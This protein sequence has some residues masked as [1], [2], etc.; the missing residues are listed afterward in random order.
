[1]RSHVK[2]NTSNERASANGPLMR[3]GQDEHVGNQDADI[4]MIGPIDAS[5]E[6]GTVATT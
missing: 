1:M 2:A 6:Y 3:Y 4:S 5:G